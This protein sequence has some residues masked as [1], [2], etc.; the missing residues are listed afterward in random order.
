MV[1]VASLG[2]CFV[3]DEDFLHPTDDEIG[4]DAADFMLFLEG[5]TDANFTLCDIRS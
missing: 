4:L 1:D 5:E 2:N 3:R